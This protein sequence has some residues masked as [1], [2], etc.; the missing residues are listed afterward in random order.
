MDQVLGKNQYYFRKMDGREAVT[1]DELSKIIP[2]DP[3]THKDKLFPRA[4]LLLHGNEDTSVPIESLQFF[5]NEV[6][7]YYNKQPENI[8]LVEI[9][10]LNHYI[11]SGMLEEIIHWLE[12][13]LN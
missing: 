7:P 2:F 5:Y 10:K 3:I 12:H 9:P 8:K 11:T 6:S 13:H 1:K 4:I